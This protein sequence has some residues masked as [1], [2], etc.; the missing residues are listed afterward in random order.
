VCMYISIYL[1]IYL[2]IICPSIISWW[3]FVQEM[4]FNSTFRVVYIMYVCLSVF[5]CVILDGT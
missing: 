3:E 1:S 2:S 5:I 4:E